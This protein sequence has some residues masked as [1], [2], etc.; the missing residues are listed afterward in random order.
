[1]YINQARKR[2]AEANPLWVQ[3][4]GQ[5]TARQQK[6][7]KLQEKLDETTKVVPP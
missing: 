3:A 1:M 6:I 7:V 2:K 4:V 5:F